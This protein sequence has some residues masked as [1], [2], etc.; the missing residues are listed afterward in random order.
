MKSLFLKIGKNDLVKG[1]IVFVLAAI[2][3]AIYEGGI[4]ST[5]IECKSIL[6]TAVIAGIGYILKNWLS[7]S[8]GKFLSKETKPTISVN[9]IK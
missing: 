9:E 1:L 3:K 4:P 5:W 8:E 2:L 6:S 7:N